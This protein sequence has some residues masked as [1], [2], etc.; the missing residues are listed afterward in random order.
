MQNFLD[1]LDI[2]IVFVDE[3]LRVK[4]FTK[5]ISRVISLTPV[6]IN[7]S[8]TDISMAIGSDRFIGTL[9]D[10]LEESEAREW[11]VES[12]DGVTYLI[13]ARPYTDVNRVRVGVLV[14]FL[15]QSP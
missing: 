8:I 4:R 1:S 9:R 13:H 2:P 7:R 14:S 6:D 10:V 15:P 3:K 11:T 12:N 5:A